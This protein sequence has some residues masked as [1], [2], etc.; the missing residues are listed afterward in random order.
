[1]DD[2]T[3]ELARA[4]EL[5]EQAAL[6]AG[7]I[8]LAHYA[9]GE[10]A[11]M[12]KPDGSPVTE[13]DL[14]A[15]RAIVGMLAAACPDDGILSEEL[16]DGEARLAKRRVWIVDPLDGTRDFIARTGDFCV[17][18]GL[19]IGGDAV[20]GAVFQPVAGRLFSARAGGG[21]RC[22]EGGAV[23]PLRVSAEA[24]PAELRVGVARLDPATPLGRCLVGAGLDGRAAVMG[25][26]VKHMAVAR[27][28]LEAAVNLSPGEQD[29]DTCAPEVIVREAGGTITDGDGRPFRY[30]GRDLAHHRG[31]VFSNGVAHAA[32]LALL[33]PALSP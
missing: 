27:G 22:R 19:A 30:N 31:S 12:T 20:V 11:V 17:H 4:L 7:A 3:D 23:T 25:A 10:V 21:A 18:V 2:L 8:L 16:P 24:R 32:L 33:R 13:A 15:N 26:S 1:V 29:W 9:R 28:A 5:A 6:A 14:D